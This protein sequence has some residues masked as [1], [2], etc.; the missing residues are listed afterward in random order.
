MYI[1]RILFIIALTFLFLIGVL[2]IMMSR[3]DNYLENKVKSALESYINTSPERLYDY[4]YESLVIDVFGGNTYLK[5]VSIAPRDSEIN[6]IE[7]KRSKGMIY[8]QLGQLSLEDLGLYGLMAD[9]TV[10][11]GKLG[12]ENLKLRY[13]TNDSVKSK[14][15]TFSISHIFSEQLKYALVHD[16][17][18]NNASISIENRYTPDS[19]SFSLD[20]AVIRFNEFFM[21]KNTAERMRPFTYDRLRINSKSVKVNSIKDY[22]LTLDSLHVDSRAKSIKLHS[23]KFEPKDFDIQNASK[24]FARSVFIIEV[25][26]IDFSSTNLFSQ[27]KINRLDIGK[28][29]IDQPSIKVGTDKRWP[30]PMHERILPTANI[31]NIPLPVK[32]DTIE[33]R[34]GYVFY[35]EFSAKGKSPLELTFNS[36]FATGFNVTNDSASLQSNPD[37][38]FFANTLFMDSSKLELKSTFHILSNDEAFNMKVNIDSMSLLVLNPILEGQMNVDVLG[39]INALEMNI[40]ANKF[41]AKG[42]LTLDYSNLKLHTFKIKETKKGEQIRSHWLINALVNPILKTNNHRDKEGFNA[43][44]VAYTRSLD[45]S[46]FTMIWQS[47]KSGLVSTVVP[48]KLQKMNSPD[49][50]SSGKRK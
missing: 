44:I 1:K 42:D 8:L 23:V 36:T 32:I 28:I 39:M 30:K 15:S 6:S 11:M 13:I 2:L 33:V 25:A 7:Q 26:E 21:D 48:A 34:D 14:E 17:H 3:I 41:G 40:D 24:Q 49:S 20:S 43:G 4:K 5:N 18:I 9:S 35:R 47:L 37:F 38:S 46:F 27:D 12:M 19:V 22:R 10:E 16:I 50:K 31:R 45:D 29:T